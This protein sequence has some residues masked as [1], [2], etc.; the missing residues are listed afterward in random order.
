MIWVSDLSIV[1]TL[2]SPPHLYVYASSLPLSRAMYGKVTA[3][4]PITMEFEDITDKATLKRERAGGGAGCRD[5]EE[6]L[7]FCALF[8]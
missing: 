3:S 1:C 4:V 7:C 8:L 5:Y 2:V 6:L